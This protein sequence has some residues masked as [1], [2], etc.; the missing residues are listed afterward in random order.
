MKLD[1]Y[2]SVHVYKFVQ[3]FFYP[4]WVQTETVLR[5]CKHSQFQ[6]GIEF[7]LFVSHEGM[8]RQRFHV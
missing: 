2:W 6:L 5:A 3:H 4:D 8:K 1:F 7:Y